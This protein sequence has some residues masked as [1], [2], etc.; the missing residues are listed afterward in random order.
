MAKTTR[1]Q[2]AAKKKP[3]KQNV[4]EWHLS[5]V[6]KLLEKYVEE[7]GQLKKLAAEADDVEFVKNAERI[8]KALS[9]ARTTLRLC[10]QNQFRAI[11]LKSGS[12][13]K[14]KRFVSTKLKKLQ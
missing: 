12:A 11:E 14:V 6:Q 9:Q 7:A 4:F 10:P 3:A 13:V 5:P 2:S 1:K 8:L